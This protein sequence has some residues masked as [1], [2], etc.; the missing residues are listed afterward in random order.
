MGRQ[1]VLVLMLYI[2][3]NANVLAQTPITHLYSAGFTWEQDL[4]IMQT[5]QYLSSF[6]PDGYNNQ[7][8]FINYD[9]FYMVSNAADSSHTDIWLGSYSN[10]TWT[11]LTGDGTAY[12]S[13]TLS[14]D[15]KWLY[16]VRVIEKEPVVQQL[17]KS[18][19]SG[20]PEFQPVIDHSMVGY[21]AIKNVD[22]I[23]VF[24]VGEPNQLWLF[25][26][27]QDK[28]PVHICDNPGRTLRI[29][30]DGS[31][32]YIHQ[33]SSDQHFLKSFNGVFV[34]KVLAQMPDGVEDF[35]L[36]DAGNVWCTSGSQIFI[37]DSKSSSSPIWK[38][39]VDLRSYGLLQL[40]R[41]SISPDGSKIIMVNHE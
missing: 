35:A 17:H 9:S 14:P 20:M 13:P 15:R 8:H 32:L 12:Y 19:A 27:N 18:L 4:L 28:L 36:D 1:W 26:V 16:A 2:L 34:D 11:R 3:R 7:V 38:L 29:H 22:S 31:L 40:K 25:F 41:I 10:L 21:F 5:P 24:T 23:Y 33:I 6:N 37:L 39:A 30:P